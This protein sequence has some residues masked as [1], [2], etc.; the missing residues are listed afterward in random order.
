MKFKSKY[1]PL[2]AEQTKQAAKLYKEGF[3]AGMIARLLK[4][5]DRV[6]TCAIKAQ[7]IWRT[8]EQARAAF[9]ERHI[10]HLKHIQKETL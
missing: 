6:V 7:G 8:P 1:P 4:S 2:T 3:G 9:E 10:K 5:S